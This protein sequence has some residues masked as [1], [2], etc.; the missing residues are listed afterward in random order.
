MKSLF[1]EEISSAAHVGEV[2][3]RFK[4]T[5]LNEEGKKASSVLQISTLHFNDGLESLEKLSGRSKKHLEAR[6]NVAVK[7]GTE[8][9]SKKS[10]WSFADKVLTSVVV[11]KFLPR[12]E[13]SK[14][15]VNFHFA[16]S[17][18]C[19]K[20]W[21]LKNVSLKTSKNSCISITFSKNLSFIFTSP[22]PFVLRWPLFHSLNFSSK[23]F[24]M[25][26][27]LISQ[28]LM[29]KKSFENCGE[30]IKNDE[31]LFPHLTWPEKSICLLLHV[32]KLD[33]TNNKTFELAP[34][35]WPHF[36]PYEFFYIAYEFVMNIRDV[37]VFP[38]KQLFNHKAIF[39]GVIYT[40]MLFL[41]Q[42]VP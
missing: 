36:L 10:P 31:K 4:V 20:R 8:K 28:P 34:P 18:A 25:K 12:R 41:Y 1:V 14:F 33:T 7:S 17:M 29:N 21:Q 24:H 27:F 13:A 6:R 15:H 23:N 11:M 40:F 5:S 3:G 35:F 38:R 16:S 30:W 42:F 37:K 2:V 26:I 39:S 9:S 19:Q 32:S 22:S